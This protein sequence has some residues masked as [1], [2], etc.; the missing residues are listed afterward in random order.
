[1]HPTNLSHSTFIDCRKR[2]QIAEITNARNNVEGALYNGSTMI[3]ELA[4]LLEKGQFI[5]NITAPD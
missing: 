3:G 2:Q 4:L 5:L 1:L